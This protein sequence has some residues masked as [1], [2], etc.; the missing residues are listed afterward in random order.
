MSLTNKTSVNLAR[1]QHGHAGILLVI[2]LPVL[3]GI[4]AFSLDG[5]RGIQTNV[6]LGEAVDSAVLAISADDVNVKL[7]DD[8]LVSNYIQS[9]VPDAVTVIPNSQITT[10]EGDTNCIHYSVDASLTLDTW[11]P[12]SGTIQGFD[13]TMLVGN[14]SQAQKGL[15]G[16]PASIDVMIVAD[17]SSSMVASWGGQQKIDALKAIVYKIADDLTEISKTASTNLMP[18]LG[19]VPY[20]NH[21]YRRPSGSLCGATELTLNGFYWNTQAVFDTMFT[22]KDSSWCKD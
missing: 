4:T 22:V 9:Y 15:S 1:H 5:S 17:A 7:T 10:C 20:S 2:L 19:V 21:V 12:G 14:S 18:T 3:W 6:R 16:V 8:I 11:F 13:E